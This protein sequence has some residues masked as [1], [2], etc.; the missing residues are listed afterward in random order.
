MLLWDDNDFG[1][2]NDYELYRRSVDLIKL[3]LNLIFKKIM[4]DHQLIQG[5]PTKHKL[6][7]AGMWEVYW[8]WFSVDHQDSFVLVIQLPPA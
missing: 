5:Y 3:Q 1:E 2:K 4:I 8:F 7:R 6:C